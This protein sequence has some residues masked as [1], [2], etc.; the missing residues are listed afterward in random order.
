MVHTIG[1]HIFCVM[2]APKQQLAKKTNCG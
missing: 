2:G 1:T